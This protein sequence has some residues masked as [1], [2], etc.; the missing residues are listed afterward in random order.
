MA[1]P[2]GRHQRRRN[3]YLCGWP[4]SIL[5][6]VMPADVVWTYSGVRPLVEDGADAKAVTRD[7]RLE[8]DRMARRC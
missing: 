7:Y 4:A 5:P 2:I 6:A 8:V 1:T 3:R